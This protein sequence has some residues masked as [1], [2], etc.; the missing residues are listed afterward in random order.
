VVKE[1]TLGLFFLFSIWLA[2]SSI[3]PAT[4]HAQL[5]YHFCW[6]DWH[7]HFK[8]NCK[9]QVLIECHSVAASWLAAYCSC[10]HCDHHPHHPVFCAQCSVRRMYNAVHITDTLRGKLHCTFWNTTTWI[11]FIRLAVCVWSMLQAGCRGVGLL[12]E[13]NYFFFIKTC[14]L[15]VGPVQPASCSV[16]TSVTIAGVWSLPLTYSLVPGFWISGAIHLSWQGPLYL[17]CGWQ[18]W[19]WPDDDHVDWLTLLN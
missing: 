18:F 12:E 4:L 3:I 5:V 1:V 11:H 17:R 6:S 7:P 2:C 9:Y 15:C 13:E 19:W 16:G 14:R 8:E 10:A